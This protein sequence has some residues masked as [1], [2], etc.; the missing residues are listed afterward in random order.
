[1][2]EQSTAPDPVELAGRLFE[3]ANRRDFD[4]IVSLFAPDAVWKANELGGAF[5]GPAAR[6]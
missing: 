4:A 6:S 3:V 1:M 2:P 5:E